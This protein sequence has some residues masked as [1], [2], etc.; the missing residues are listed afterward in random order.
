MLDIILFELQN[1]HLISLVG[2]VEFSIDN[3]DYFWNLLLTKTN[4]GHQKPE[5][6]YI[7]PFCLDRL[8]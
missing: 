8:I 3:I 5:T 6:K 2:A 1:V 7:Y 4:N